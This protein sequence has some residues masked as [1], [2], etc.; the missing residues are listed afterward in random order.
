MGQR[1]N[2]SRPLFLL[3]YLVDH[4]DEDHQLTVYFLFENEI[5]KLLESVQG[6][7]KQTA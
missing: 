6:E 2:K 5:Q 7:T 1:T 4:T 3:R